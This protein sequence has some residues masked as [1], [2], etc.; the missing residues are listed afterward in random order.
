M[1][2]MRW[3]HI[4][5]SCGQRVARNTL[6]LSY[7][8]SATGTCKYSSKDDR[9]PRTIGNASVHCS[10][11]WHMMSAFSVQCR[12]STRSLEAG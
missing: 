8:R 12:G 10:S 11:A 4:D 6:G 1:D 2:E 7:T 9:M 3:L 5:D